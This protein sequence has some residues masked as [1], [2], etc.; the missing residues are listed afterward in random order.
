MCPLCGLVLGQDTWTL[1]LV[2]NLLSR[3][4]GDTGVTLVLERGC[5]FCRPAELSVHF[6]LATQVAGPSEGK[7]TS[8]HGNVVSLGGEPASWGDGRTHCCYCPS[9]SER[10]RPRSHILS[11]AVIPCVL[12]SRPPALAPSSHFVEALPALWLMQFSAQSRAA[13]HTVGAQY[14]FVERRQE[15]KYVRERQRINAQGQGLA[16]GLSQGPLAAP[17]LLQGQPP[18]A[19][20]ARLPD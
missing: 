5:L 14:I 12:C 17:F 18:P 19:R 7:A 11:G 8:P 9:S 4:H 1:H 6:P 16:W 13:G 2:Q 20:N 10:L 3:S 15:R